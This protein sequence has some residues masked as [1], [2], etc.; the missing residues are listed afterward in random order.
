A[1]TGDTITIIIIMV[2]L[3]VMGIVA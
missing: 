1:Y 3:A 2:C